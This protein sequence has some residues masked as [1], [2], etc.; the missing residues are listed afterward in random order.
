[1]RPARRI[2][3]VLEAVRNKYKIPK[4][5]INELQ[6]IWEDNP[7][8]RFTQLLVNTNIIPNVPGS[9][10]YQEDLEFMVDDLGVAPR[11]CLLWG[12]Y[13]KDGKDGKGPVKHLLLRE[14]TNQHI[15][16]IL[17][18]QAHVKGKLR[19]YFNTE[20][21]YREENDIVITD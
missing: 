9:W 20:L 17:E 3:I 11:D 14:M 21:D 1:M 19:E 13:G 10:Y 16:A 12:S 7:D 15:E 4:K 18:T 8:L 6:K 2:P 5:D